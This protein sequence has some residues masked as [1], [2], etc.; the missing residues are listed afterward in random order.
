MDARAL[1]SNED[2]Q[3]SEARHGVARVFRLLLA[4]YLGDSGSIVVTSS[5]WRFRCDAGRDGT[6]RDRYIPE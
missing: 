2:E 6:R 5:C 1:G 3:L 4:S